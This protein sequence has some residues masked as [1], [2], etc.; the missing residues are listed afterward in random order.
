MFSLI[1]QNRIGCC[2]PFMGMGMMFNPRMNFFLGFAGAFAG[3]N[4]FSSFFSLGGYPSCNCMSFPFHFGS[5]STNN[6]YGSLYTTSYRSVPN[7]SY[8][9]VYNS[10]PSYSYGGLDSFLTLTLPQINIPSIT[11]PC[12]QSSSNSSTRSDSKSSR[13]PIP[14]Q[15]EKTLSSYDEN[16]LPEIRNSS[17]MKNVPSARKSRILSAVQNS[18]KKYNVDPKLVISMMYAESNFKP[19]ATSHC[20][21][22]GLMQLMPG[23]AKQY[24]ASDPYNIE[25]NIDAAVKFIKYLKGRYNGNMDLMVAAYNAGPGRVKNSVPNISE[26]KNYVAKVRRTYNSLA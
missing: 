26:T 10:T 2:N 18:C 4:P 19:D 6:P 24:G 7:S 14:S 20:G 3:I 1:M 9:F 5:Y 21:A 15:G 11:V 23:T 16:A 12:V 22:A 17:L 25:Q 8:K 13:F